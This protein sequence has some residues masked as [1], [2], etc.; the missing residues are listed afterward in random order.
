MKQPQKSGAR[1]PAA[2]ERAPSAP[3]TRSKRK[4][5]AREVADAPSEESPE[6]TPGDERIAQRAY[7]LY[8]A[9]DGADGDAVA[10]WL[11]AERQIRREMSGR[12]S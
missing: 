6:I 9:R 12:R 11:E 2:G 10:D 3:A 8:L 7:A 1:P 4:V 5:Q